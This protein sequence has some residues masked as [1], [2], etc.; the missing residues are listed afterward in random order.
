[1]QD[2]KENKENKEK[3]E[4]KKFEE[5]KLEVEKYLQVPVIWGGELSVS[6]KPEHKLTLEYFGGLNKIY[7]VDYFVITSTGLKIFFKK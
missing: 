6:F 5:T 4:E 2:S 3:K 1:M 7:K